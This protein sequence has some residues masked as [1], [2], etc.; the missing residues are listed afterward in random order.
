MRA[1]LIGAVEGTRVALDAI[2]AAPGW[3]LAA[4]ATLPPDRA[5]RHSDYVDLT[6]P[7]AAAG[8]QL[9]HVVEGNGAAFVEQVRAVA[10]DMTF[11]IGWSQLCGP[12]LRAAV[13]D[14]VVGYHTAALPRLR[15]RATIPWTILLD[16]KITGST[17]F[18]IDDGV[19]SGAI[20]AQRFFHVAP[21]ETALTLYAK[22][23][24]ALYDMLD[25]LLPR[26]AQGEVA[27]EVQDERLATWATRRRPDDGRIDWRRPADDIHRL[28]RAVGRPY[29]GAF[30]EARDAR[31][32]IW[33]TEPWQD[34]AR[35]HALPGQVIARDADGFAVCCGDGRALLIVES[36]AIKP[37][38][39][40]S[41]L[42][43]AQ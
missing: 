16:E 9:I 42:G 28:V 20:M 6:D 22:H 15:G 5:A 29:P 43:T 13:N 39:M 41:H 4:V 14:R 36:D 18:R 1:L 33:R 21:D 23:M 12:A 30:T 32:T 27:G 34:G 40:H 3:T 25:D 37:P 31:I 24:G 2:A 19:D 35:H 38:A 17:L 26:L 11:V 8:A 10:P 7:A